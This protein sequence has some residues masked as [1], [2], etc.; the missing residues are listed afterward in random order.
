VLQDRGARCCSIVGIQINSSKRAI[1]LA[2]TFTSQLVVLESLSE[3]LDSRLASV[4]DA[5]PYQSRPRK[6]TSDLQSPQ[7][8][9]VR[10]AT[11]R[12]RLQTMRQRPSSPAPSPSGSRL[13]ALL[14]FRL[15]RQNLTQQRINRVAFI[16]SFLPLPRVAKTDF[17][18]PH[19]INPIRA[20]HMQMASHDNLA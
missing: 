18:K 3:S 9:P 10:R 6:I 2:C 8:R 14:R 20:P 12:H 13:I 16:L 7:I 4:I 15:P 19:T 17:L 1:G 11:R 5:K